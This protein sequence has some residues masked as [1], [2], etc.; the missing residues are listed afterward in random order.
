[1]TRD[2]EVDLIGVQWTRPTLPDG[3]AP[4]EP[5]PEPTPIAGW[6]VNITPALL[7]LRP[8]LEP[9][10]MTPPVRRVWAGDDPAAPALT[11]ALRF[12]DESEAREILAELWPDEP[13]A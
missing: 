2:T 13:S 4:G 7:S 6:R 10:V 9:F 1:M 8:D 12:D 3:W 11:V 5:R